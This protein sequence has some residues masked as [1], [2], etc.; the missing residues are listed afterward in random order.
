MSETNTEATPGNGNLRPPF[1][2]GVSGNPKG[3]PKGAKSRSTIVREWLEME[4]DGEPNIDRV[5]R[6]LIKKASEGDIPAIK[7]A[8]DSAFGKLT[9]K[10]ELSG[11]DGQPVTAILRTVVDPKAE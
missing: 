10:Q 1:P 2:K 6:A 5:M 8:L 4:T 9:D 3:R 7:E 11:P